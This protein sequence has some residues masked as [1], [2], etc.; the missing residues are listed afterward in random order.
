MGAALMA[1]K[2]AALS[3]TPAGV[4]QAVPCH[5]YPGLRDLQNG[6][7]D[8]ARTTS[9][10]HLGV[11][12]PPLRAA[13]DDRRRDAHLEYK[14]LNCRALLLTGSMMINYYATKPEQLTSFAHGPR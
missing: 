13:Q 3:K 7:K 11:E 8:L 14:M 10:P 2:A 12:G 1:K 6:P 5:R 4:K 9:R